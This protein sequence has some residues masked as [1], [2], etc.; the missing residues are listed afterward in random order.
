MQI[1]SGL[2]VQADEGIPSPAADRGL[3]P[4][5]RLCDNGREVIGRGLLD[6]QYHRATSSAASRE[7]RARRLAVGRCCAMVEA[8]AR[9][10]APVVRQVARLRCA[11]RGGVLTCGAHDFDG[12]GRRSGDVVT[13]DFF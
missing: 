11:C 1:S 4:R 10:V 2:L 5:A 9:D 13:A 6:A 7:G 8:T 12:G 3:L